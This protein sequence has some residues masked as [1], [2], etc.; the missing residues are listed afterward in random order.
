MF[1][2]F[3][4]YTWWDE[5]AITN[6]RN[7]PGCRQYMNDRGLKFIDDLYTDLW[8]ALQISYSNMGEH[9]LFGRVF[10]RKVMTKFQR[11]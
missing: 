5:A 9:Q 1:P 6:W 11:M 2:Y 10:P 7:C 8:L 4:T 3:H